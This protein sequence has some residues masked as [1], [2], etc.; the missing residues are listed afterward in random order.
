M[1]KL[2]KRLIGYIFLFI[3]ILG[4][5]G[6]YVYTN[7]YKKLPLESFLESSITKRVMPELY[8]VTDTL[9]TPEEA[10]INDINLK[11]QELT[12]Q[13]NRL[14]DERAQMNV[15]KDSL[16]YFRTMAYE[17]VREKEQQK[18]EKIGKLAKIYETMK[19]AQ[20]APILEELDNSTIISILESMRERQIAQILENMDQDR[21]IEISRAMTR[22][23]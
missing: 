8:A 4:A 18:S 19:P 5:V 3:I 11:Q 12:I 17:L 15:I 6:Y 14:L 20:V 23:R 9:I 10:L 2:I 22:V 13:E 21:A 7:R 1:K 16:D